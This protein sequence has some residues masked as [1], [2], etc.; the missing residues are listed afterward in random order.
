M[1]DPFSISVGALAVMSACVTLGSRIYELQ[2]E[3]RVVDDELRTLLM[4]I[5]G[6]KDLC[7]T[8]KATYE[9]RSAD[10]VPPSTEQAQILDDLWAHLGNAL[11]N[12]LT[13]IKKLD[14]IF[15]KIRSHT[16]DDGLGKFDAV[17][18]V[19]KKRLKE[20]DLQECRAQMAAYQSALQIVLSLITRHD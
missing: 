11:E 6:L 16:G 12:C 10:A 14:G 17:V 1:A 9:T 4:D 19:F 13:V 8:V 2:K 3:S 5:N 15:S 7:Q 20:K 18:T